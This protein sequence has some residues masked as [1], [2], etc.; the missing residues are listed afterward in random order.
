MSDPDNPA[1]VPSQ[2]APLASAAR[3][4]APAAS[5]SGSA[6]SNPAPSISTANRPSVVKE[7]FSYKSAASGGISL[8][9]LKDLPTFDGSNYKL[10]RKCIDDYLQ[11][12]GLDGIAAGVGEPTQ[13][14]LK[15]GCH[16]AASRSISR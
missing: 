4:A 11:I 8:S 15:I 2:A 6:G 1:P 10:W 3:R 12:S 9:G 13:P 16:S 7:T 5:S 14:T